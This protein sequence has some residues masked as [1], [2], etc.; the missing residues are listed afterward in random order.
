MFDTNRTGPNEGPPVME[1]WTIATGAD[2]VVRKV[3]ITHPHEF[4]R[5]DERLFGREH[6]FI[7]AAGVQ[8]DRGSSFCFDTQSGSLKIHDHGQLRFGSECVFV[9]RSADAAEGDGWVLTYVWDARFNTSDLVIIDTN[10]FDSE[11]VARVKLPVRV[12]FGFHG[13]WVRQAELA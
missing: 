5:V 11:P 1:H 4:P 3:T 7:F 8:T 12:P 10:D 2:R 9:P 13:S 6:R